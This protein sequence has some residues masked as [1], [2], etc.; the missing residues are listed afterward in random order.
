MKAFK[1]IKLIS[2]SAFLLSFISVSQP[3]TA[4]VYRAQIS[5]QMPVRHHVTKAMN[6]FVK[7]ANAKSGGRL[8]L[9]HFPSSQLLTDREVPKA[10]NRGTIQMAQTSFIWWKGIIPSIAVFGGKQP[11]TFEQAQRVTRGPLDQFR[12]KKLAKA[13]KPGRLDVKII[14]PLMYGCTGGFIL[15]RPAQELGDMKGMKIRIPSRSL[16]A[17]VQALGG[18]PTVMS[19][20]DVYMS[21]Q[22]N[23]IQG[24]VSGLGS[25]YAR[26]WY[27]GAKHVFIL[28]P[29]YTDFHIVA[30]RTWFNNLPADL[31]QVILDAGEVASK[32]A[33]KMA[34]GMEKKLESLLVAKGVKIH[35]V[36]AEDF[37]VKWAPVIEPALRKSAVKQF[38]IEAADTWDSWIT[39]AQ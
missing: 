14:A 34:L 3:A 15:K 33:T 8:K 27:E 4:K 7:T 13:Y 28:R 37:K 1:I 21:I 24:A 32:A 12:R 2:C 16:A 11:A 36:S 9:A 39:A 19:S 18:V 22:R 23:T 31:Q 29:M 10:I 17:E 5:S 25:F 20:A 6:L 35:K 30:N 38:G 26:K